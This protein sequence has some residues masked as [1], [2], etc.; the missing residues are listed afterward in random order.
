MAF[1]CVYLVDTGHL[2]FSCTHLL[3]IHN[4]LDQ[5]FLISNYVGIIASL[6]FFIAI[7]ESPKYLL[8]KKKYDQ[9]AKILNYIAWFNGRSSRFDQKT[10]FW[11]QKKEEH[12]ELIQNENNEDKNTIKQNLKELFSSKHRTTLFCC[13]VAFSCAIQIWTFCMYNSSQL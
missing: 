10:A 3:M 12:K 9:V 6:I 1:S 13:V 5:Y 2:I 7:P 4:D 8:M 11:S